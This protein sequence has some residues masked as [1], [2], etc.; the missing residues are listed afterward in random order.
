MTSIE[1]TKALAAALPRL[2]DYSQPNEYWLETI[3]K[4]M[5]AYAGEQNAEVKQNA[6]SMAK[7]SLMYSADNAQ[8]KEA[9]RELLKD[10]DELMEMFEWLLRDNYITGINNVRVIVGKLV[11]K[12]KAL[13]KSALAKE[14]SE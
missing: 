8:L 13:D 10:K 11:A 9:N 5:E 2:G 7:L 3:Q 14:R 4:A 1:H 6:E 12:H